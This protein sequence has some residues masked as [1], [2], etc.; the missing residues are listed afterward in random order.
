MATMTLVARSSSAGIA[1]F[2]RALALAVP[3]AAGTAQAQ[4]PYPAK[5]VRVVVAFAPGGFADTV[6]RVVGHKLGERL[7]QPILV[8]NRPGAGGNLAAKYVAESAPDGYTLLA[9]TAASA[10][11]VT[12]YDNPGFD[13]LKDLAPVANTGSTPG[14]FAVLASHPAKDLRELIRTAKGRRLSYAT[15]GI[16]TS[17]HISAD[18]LFR[19][20]SGLDAVHVPFKGGGPA[21]VAVLGGQVEIL[22]SSSNALPYIRQGKMKALAVASLKRVETLPDAPTVA[23]LGFPGY[24][25]RSWVGIFAP[26]RTPAAVVERL[27]DEINR[28]LALPEVRA[29]LAAQGMDTHPGTSAAFAEYVR[30]EVAKWSKM[31]KATGVTAE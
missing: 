28:I 25:E 4:Q 2:A 20:A 14:I 3:I 19:V 31:V 8:E 6:S 24:E 9:H 13:F 21:T 12:L 29:S 22:S 5:P 30:G 17:S 16:G 18:Y 15:A 26:A 7:R 1:A 11:N 23:E 10:I 27:N